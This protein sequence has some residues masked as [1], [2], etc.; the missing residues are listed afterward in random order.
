MLF[1][2]VVASAGTTPPAQIVNDVPK[3]K[4]G[5][6]FEFM[7]TVNIKGVAHSPA[8]G[9]NVYV[10]EVRLLT[11]AGLHTPVIL[12]EDTVGNVGTLAPSHIA[13]DDPKLKVGATIGFTVTV[14]VAG[15][16]HCPASGV[17]V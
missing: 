15:K 8:A 3:L 16:A 14:N 9:V 10:P 6:V 5:V 12:L 11:T 7:F 2:D 1:V 17:N 13:N 4:V